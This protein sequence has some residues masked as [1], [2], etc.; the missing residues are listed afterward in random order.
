M[1]EDLF[2]AIRGGGGASFGVV[3]SWKI[4][5]VYVPPVVTVFSLSKTL[6]EDATRLV[7]KWQHIAHNITEDLFINLVITPINS[8]M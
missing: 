8:T 7:N 4:N 3:L 1:G 2:W 6:D 5:L